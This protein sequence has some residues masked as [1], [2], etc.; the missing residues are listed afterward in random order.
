M[1]QWQMGQA[2]PAMNA[3]KK[4][5]SLTIPPAAKRKGQ[6]GRPVLFKGTRK[7]VMVYLDEAEHAKL[8]AEAKRRGM[9]LSTLV[10][11]LILDLIG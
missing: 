1:A 11:A 4:R 7:Q 5:D 3:R 2:L 9:K 8:E 6:H 10:R